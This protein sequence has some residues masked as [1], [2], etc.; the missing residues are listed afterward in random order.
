M[1][2]NPATKRVTQVLGSI[3]SGDLEGDFGGVVNSIMAEY[4]LYK[5]FMEEAREITE[6]NY[7]GGAYLDGS[8]TKKVKFDRIY[9]NWEPTYDNEKVL[10]VIGERDYDSDE[11]V[12]LTLMIED[13]EEREKAQLRKL[14][15]KYP[16][17]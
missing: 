7:R 17:G 10:Q 15:E 4:G 12:A 5:K 2:Y 11:L 9:L 1:H 13:Q 8:K 14:K 3:Y 6:T 16:N